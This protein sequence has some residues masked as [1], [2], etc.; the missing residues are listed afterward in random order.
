MR[1]R[2]YADGRLLRLVRMIAGKQ[3]SHVARQ[4]LTN[5]STVSRMENGELRVPVD[6]AQDFI[7][8]CGGPEVLKSLLDGLHK[9]QDL[10]GHND[11]LL[12]A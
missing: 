1:R 11:H 8:S 10:V 7:D 4:L 12:P 2:Q 9:L 6:V 3:Q 5:Q